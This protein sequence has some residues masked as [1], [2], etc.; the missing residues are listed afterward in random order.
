MR[1]WLR[2]SWHGSPRTAFPVVAVLAP[3]PWRLRGGVR[4]LPGPESGLHHH[5]LGGLVAR[6][7]TCS[8][9]SPR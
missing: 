2:A 7:C 4:E 6:S 3:P 8:W 9:R 5:E 1:A